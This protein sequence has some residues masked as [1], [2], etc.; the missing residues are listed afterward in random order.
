MA[1]PNSSCCHLSN[2]DSPNL[3]YASLAFQAFSIFNRRKGYDS[4]QPPGQGYDYQPFTAIIPVDQLIAHQVAIRT[5]STEG[6]QR[7]V[8]VLLGPKTRDQVLNSSYEY[9]KE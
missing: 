6:Q 7:V 1:P 5:C 2:N 8:V 3:A 4:K 9:F